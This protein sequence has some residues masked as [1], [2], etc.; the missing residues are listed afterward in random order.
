MVKTENEIERDLYALLV[1]SS[2]ADSVGGGVYRSGLRP[3][4][5]K[6]EDVTVKLLSAN[7]RQVQSGTIL[8]HVYVPSLQSE[9]GRNV[10]DK[11]RMGEI[12]GLLRQWL[13][14]C[15]HGEYFMEADPLPYSEY[16]ADVNQWMVICKVSFRR[17][18]EEF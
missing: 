2:L 18:T 12:E 4:D 15:G 13:D 5:S 16:Q 1:N 3:Y 9:A 7:A 17:C 6:A 10:P 14:E 8:I 11:S